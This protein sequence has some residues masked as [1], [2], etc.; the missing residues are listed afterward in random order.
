MNKS[1]LWGPKGTFRI[2]AILAVG[3]LFFMASCSGTKYYDRY[4][5]DKPCKMSDNGANKARKK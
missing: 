3:L 2:V 1:D 4:P 5:K